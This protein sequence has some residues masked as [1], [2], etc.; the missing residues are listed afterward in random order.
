MT[1]Q[2]D[3]FADSA[4]DPGAAL[5]DPVGENLALLE[6]VAA[7]CVEC[8]LPRTTTCSEGDCGPW[9]LEQAALDELER[10]RLEHQDPA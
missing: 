3:G 7:F 1:S 10:Y 8:C 2:V 9:R 5:P 4:P 6:A